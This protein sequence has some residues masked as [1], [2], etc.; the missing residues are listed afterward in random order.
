MVAG[1]TTAAAGPI[2]SSYS[3]YVLVCFNNYQCQNFQPEFVLSQLSTRVRFVK[4]LQ[5]RLCLFLRGNKKITHNQLIICTHLFFNLMSSNLKKFVRPK[6]V[7]MNSSRV[8][9]STNYEICRQQFVLKVSF[10]RKLLCGTFPS[11]TH[12]TF[13]STSKCLQL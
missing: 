2:L 8:E 7:E 4:S 10:P 5:N 6:F 12:A 13:Q 9:S 11:L 3:L 1:G